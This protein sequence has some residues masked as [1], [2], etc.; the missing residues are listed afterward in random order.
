MVRV[1]LLSIC[2]LALLTGVVLY[3]IGAFKTYPE[4]GFNWMF[5]VIPIALLSAVIAFVPII[6]NLA[7]NNI[8]RGMPTIS[9]VGFSI[10]VA[11]FVGV[12][13]AQFISGED[14]TIFP[15]LIMLIMAIWILYRNY[16]RR[17]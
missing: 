2:T 10:A 9:L 8:L 14:K 13:V 11:I 16:K 1:L 12:F 15:T 17:H 4:A 7:K 6:I 3:V 5:V